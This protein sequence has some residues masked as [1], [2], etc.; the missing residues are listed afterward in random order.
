MLIYISITFSIYFIDF[1]EHIELIIDG[2]EQ[3]VINYGFT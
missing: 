2:G 3:Y 1:T